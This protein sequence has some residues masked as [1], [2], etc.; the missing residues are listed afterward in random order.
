MNA[1][2]SF[3]LVLL[4]AVVA[5]AVTIAVIWHRPHTKV[6]DV[7][8][9]TVTADLLAA[10]YGGNE[11]AANTKYL[12]KAIEVSG[13]VSEIDKNQDGGSMVVL[14]TGDPMTGVQ[15]TLR[16][17]GAP[18]EKGKN[19]ILKGFCTGANLTGVTLT[20]CIIVH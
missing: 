18:P 6:E 8:G 12:N 15:C 11:Q 9:V 17:K 7:T 20:D 4:G 2:K 16:D 3:A 13:T 5:V 10:A 14:G 19:V 1:R